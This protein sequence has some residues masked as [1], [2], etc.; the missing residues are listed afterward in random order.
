MIIGDIS[1]F[2]IESS[3][4]TPLA[5]KSQLGIGYFV[6]H[7]NGQVYGVHSPEATVLGCSF[8]SVQDRIKQ[9]GSHLA[10][11]C[12]EEAYKV[13]DAVRAAEFD[14]NRQD[15]IFFDGLSAEDLRASLS[16]NSI[17]WAP[18][19]DAAFD[20]SSIVL[21]FDYGDMVRIVAFK[22]LEDDEDFIGTI[23]SVEIELEGYY[24]LLAEW[25]RQ[26]KAE[27]E[28]AILSLPN[29]SPNRLT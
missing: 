17:I 10:P 20:D 6:L 9:R 14:E 7:I 11:F 1:S 16:D 27:W 21:Q 18:D 8:Y 13:A 25:S 22:N 15:D 23:E 3:I 28:K 19:G 26:F 4:T 12:S 24:G 29:Q 2:A 5:R